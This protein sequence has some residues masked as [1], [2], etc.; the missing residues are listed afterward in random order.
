MTIRIAAFTIVAC[1]S[2]LGSTPRRAQVLD[3]P[4]GR[5]VVV[6]R[7]GDASVY[8]GWRLLRTDDPNGGFNVY[9]TTGTSVPVK[10]TPAPIATTTDYVDSSADLAQA[11]TYSVRPVRGGVEQAASAGA[12][13]PANAVVQQFLTV[14]LKRPAGG[15]VDVPPGAPTMNYTYSPNDASVG[16]LDGDGAYEVV[17]KSWLTTTAYADNYCVR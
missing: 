15:T 12:T 3:E 11:N 16:D 7:T 8:I 13:L 10:I 5:G 14:P 2:F 1:A 9:R 17:L 4:L 6:V